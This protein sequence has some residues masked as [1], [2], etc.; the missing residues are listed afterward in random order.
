MM[1]QQMTMQRKQKIFLACT[2]GSSYD[3][4]AVAPIAV[5]NL[6]VHLRKD[7][8]EQNPRTSR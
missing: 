2:I 6:S 3:R 1:C 7:I 8:D 5:D 4:L